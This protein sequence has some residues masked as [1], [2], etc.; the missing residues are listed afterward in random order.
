[1]EDFEKKIHSHRKDCAQGSSYEKLPET[2]DF[3][4]A[5]DLSHK[6]LKFN[7]IPRWLSFWPGSP[8]KLGGYDVRCGQVAELRPCLED[9]DREKLG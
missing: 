3:R 2:S 4:Y 9:R 5:P 8:L 6:N 1:M 7:R